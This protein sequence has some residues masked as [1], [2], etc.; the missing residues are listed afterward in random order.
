MILVQIFESFFCLFEK[1]YKYRVRTETHTRSKVLVAN[2]TKFFF[3][4]DTVSTP[5]SPV[6]SVC[7]VQFRE[8][9]GWS[10]LS[11]EKY[12]YDKQ[13]SSKKF[14]QCE[15]YCVNSEDTI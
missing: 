10:E 8:G 9:G 5:F 1:R 14:M 13:K 2:F 3:A 6:L 11:T 12:I 7:E 4:E 15:D